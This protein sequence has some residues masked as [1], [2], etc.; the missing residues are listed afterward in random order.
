MDPASVQD[1]CV[2]K[3]DSRYFTIGSRLAEFT[4]ANHLCVIINGVL[5][6]N[7]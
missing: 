2:L 5:G 6:K 3:I 4:V 1:A 7:V